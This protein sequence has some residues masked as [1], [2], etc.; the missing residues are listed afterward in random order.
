MEPFF[1]GVSEESA[2]STPRSEMRTVSAE[3]IADMNRFLE[4]NVRLGGGQ[5]QGFEGVTRKLTDGI[6]SMVA[7]TLK[8]TQLVGSFFFP[9]AQAQEIFDAA[10]VPATA[11]EQKRFTDARKVLLGAKTL[12]A[13]D[14][15]ILA[16]EFGVDLGAALLMRKIVGDAPVAVLVR[17]DT[18]RKFLGQINITLRQ[19]NRPLIFPAATLEEAAQFLGRSVRGKMNIKPMVSSG[20]KNVQAGL[21]LQ[22]YGNAVITVTPKMYQSFLNLAGVSEVITRLREEYL[23]TARSA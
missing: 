9:T 14:V 17:D 18:D 8:A 10:S 16:P 6:Y 19:A 7:Q 15:L 13:S 23:A 22:Q 11:H 4:E 21:L 12:G 20:E 5:A 3:T 2:P 1:A